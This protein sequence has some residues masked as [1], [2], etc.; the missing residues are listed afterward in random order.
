MDL[1]E[2]YD[3]RIENITKVMKKYGIKDLEKARKLCQDKGFDPYKITKGSTQLATLRWL[4]AYVPRIDISGPK[5][6]GLPYRHASR[7]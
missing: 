3:R 5:V 7:G 2:N 6:Y 4:S 1:F